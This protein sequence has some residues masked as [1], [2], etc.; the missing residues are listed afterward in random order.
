MDT[1]I[2]QKE[3]E[4]ILTKDFLNKEYIDN[5][6][7]LRDISKITGAGITTISIYLRKYN[8]QTRPS[9]LIRTTPITNCIDCGIELCC[10]SS[11]GSCL[12]CK[13]CNYIF[14]L[15]ENNPNWQGG[16][17]KISCDYCQK[18]IYRQK[19][20]VFNHNF[21]NRKCYGKFKQNRLIVQC[22]VCNKKIE[23]TPSNI[24]HHIFC[25]TNCRDK[26]VFHGIMI[27]YKNRYFRS[28]WE[29]NFAKWLDLSEI[30]WLYEPRGFNLFIKNKKT[31]YYPD[32]YLP[33]FDLWIEVKGYW[34]DDA[35]EKHSMFLKTYKDINI[36]IFEKNKL[37]EIGVI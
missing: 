36:E 27:W 28:S 4:K 6:K 29:A 12:R 24:S 20:I 19:S 22:E 13:S 17:I 5:N 8:I 18:I 33:E 25:S 16:D 23:R 34:R 1:G 21:C 31:K 35:K 30:K 9:H 3:L 10:S 26:K 14:I 15:N 37:L 11:K 7:S 2:R 32:F